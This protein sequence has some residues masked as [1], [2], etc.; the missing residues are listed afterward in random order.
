M[1]LQVPFAISPHAKPELN[2]KRHRHDNFEIC[3]VGQL[4]MLQGFGDRA[5]SLGGK[6]NECEIMF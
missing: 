4:D 1:V 3:C 5:V 6:G 2:K